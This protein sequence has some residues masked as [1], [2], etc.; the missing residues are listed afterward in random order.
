MQLQGPN[1]ILRN[2]Q[3]TD[4]P[5]LQRNADNKKISDNLLDRFPSPYTLAA[6]EGWV[7][8]WLG[9]E[10]MVNF[11]IVQGDEVI[12][13]I[14]L[15]LRQDVYR[16]TPLLGYW[17]AEQYWGKGIMPQA[18]KL[19]VQHAFD[20]LGAMAVV[21]YALSKNPASMRVLEK[22]GFKACGII[23]KSVVKNNEVWDEHIFAVH[24]D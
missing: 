18:V 14:G 7:Q 1:F 4:A 22:A 15:E 16:K 23:P 11:A 13:G 5:S 19:I 12:G 20:N 21:A 17:L 10:P 2:W 9:Q 24:K 6:A 8:M 3:L